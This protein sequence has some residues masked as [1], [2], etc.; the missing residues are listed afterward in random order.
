ML[1]VANRK[2]EKAMTLFCRIP[3]SF[4]LLTIVAGLTLS[5]CG[6][7]PESNAPTAATGVAQQHEHPTEGPHHGSLIELGN[8]EYHGELV[9]D[10][11]TG[12]VMIYILDSTAKAAVPIEATEVTINLR[13]EGQAQQFKLA[14]DPDSDDPEGKAS[15]FTS[16]DASLGEALDRDDS[17]AHLVVTIDG[18]Q[19]RGAV[20]HDHGAHEHEN[21]DHQEPE[22]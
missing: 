8:E 21:H 22:E 5:G 20:V 15:K 14:A 6:R 17:E 3:V 11:A 19:Y 12:S 13:H 7:S 2:K 16:S 10:E 4:I 9:H 1:K 18:K